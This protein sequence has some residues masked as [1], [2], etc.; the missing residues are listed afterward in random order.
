MVVKLTKICLHICEIIYNLT[1]VGYKSAIYIK[2][3][4]KISNLL[5]LKNYK[6]LEDK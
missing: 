2:T 5:K 1:E 4:V 6:F 3:I